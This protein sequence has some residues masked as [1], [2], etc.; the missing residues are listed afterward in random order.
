MLSSFAETNIENYNERKNVYLHSHQIPERMKYWSI[1]LLL[2]F[3][4]ACSG[5]SAQKAQTAQVAEPTFEMVSVPTLITEPAERAAYLSEHYWDK[6]NFKDIAYIHYSAVTEQAMSNYI[7]VLKYVPA[8]KA[9]TSIKTMLGKAEADT[10]MFNFLTKLYEKYLYNANSPM[11][12]DEFFIPVLETII[13]APFIDDAHKIR[14]RSLLSLA[15]KNRVGK[16]ANDFT[17]TYIDGRKAKMYGIKADYLVLFFNNPDCEAC[18]EMTGKLKDSA[19][20]N[21]LL[22]SHK[23]V[24]LSVY[25]DADLDV[26]KQHEPSMPKSW[27]NAYDNGQVITNDELYDLKAS[28]TVYLLDKDKNVILKDASFDELVNYFTKPDTQGSL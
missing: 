26:W 27:I 19:P 9:A 3:F 22:D 28:P 6:F 20:I 1:L 21:E 8:D 7:D 15:M 25:P 17:Y 4:Q 11:H 14:P 23:M 2:P 18:I 16:K 5:Q 13:A 12:N 24:L 10:A